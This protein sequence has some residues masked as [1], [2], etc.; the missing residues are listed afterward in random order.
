MKLVLKKKPKNS[1]IIE[2]FPGFGL[3]G[4]ITTEY[5]INVLKAELIGYVQAEEAPPLVAIHE[6]NLVQ[7]IGIYYAA[8]QNLIIMHIMTNI[9]GIEWDMGQKL[10][11][12]YKTLGAK[13]LI[14][15]EGVGTPTVSEEINAYHYANQKKNA[16]KFAKLGFTKLKEG[17]ILG[18]SATL[19]LQTEAK[20]ALSCIFVETHSNLPDSKAAAKSIEVLDKYLGLKIDYQPLLEQAKQFE[21]KIKGLMEKSA[22]AQD[23]SDK[24]NLSYLG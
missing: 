24:K 7:P 15:I 12:A 17:I 23:D 2:G 20:I 22:V 6:G 19:L 11:E 13:E 5:L 8:K 1:T 3:V 10:I 21:E 18:V 16:D 4:T 9:K 14:S